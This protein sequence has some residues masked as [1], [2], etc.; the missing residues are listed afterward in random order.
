MKNL[1]NPQEIHIASQLLFIL[2]IFSPTIVLH[3]ASYIFFGV[4]LEDY[5]SQRFLIVGSAIKIISVFYFFYGNRF[6]IVG[7]Y[8][9]SQIINLVSGVLFLIIARFRYNHTFASY[10]RALRLS[11]EMYHKLKK[12]SHVSFYLTVVWILIYELDM[13][14]IARLIGTTSTAY[15]GV[16]LTIF[17]FLRTIYGLLYS[18]YAARM[19]HFIGKG[20]TEGLKAFLSHIISI[21][22][23]A[24]IFPVLSIILLAH[25]LIYTW[26]G[27]TYDTSIMLLQWL[28][29]SYL[30][31]FITYVVPDLLVAQERIKAMYII[32]TANV[33]LYWVGILTTFSYL[34]IISF[35]IFKF[36]IFA[37]SAVLYSIIFMRFLNLDFKNFL[38][39]FIHPI[40][41]P[42]ICAV[43]ILVCIEP[44]MPAIKNKFY[45]MIVVL[46]GIGVASI[47]IILYACF[48]SPFR[49][50][51]H[52]LY[53]KI[54]AA[55][56]RTRFAA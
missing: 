34:G 8:L 43:G 24:V 49:S 44:L 1:T 28:V 38:K 19:N 45:V 37:L 46:T 11:K 27:N 20:D 3:R 50:Y 40:I 53:Q 7:Y 52:H 56:M 47:G 15:Y 41:I 10:L 21:T 33:C 32:G 4:R 36:S 51:A 29:C 39:K 26:V 16:A 14:I 2:A 25:P 42:C 13:V 54:R 6:D 30:F 5:I 35:V 48:C 55:F 12:I 22:M 31:A 18:P 17:T 9:F 23:P